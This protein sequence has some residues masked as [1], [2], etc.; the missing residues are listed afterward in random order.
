MT[1]GLNQFNPV[2]NI[3]ASSAINSQLVI[4][5]SF[6]TARLANIYSEMNSGEGEVPKSNIVYYNNLMGNEEVWRNRENS[7]R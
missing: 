7:E 4:D 3:V 2:S 6:M 5:D 1:F